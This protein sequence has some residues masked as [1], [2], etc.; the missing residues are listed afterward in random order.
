MSFTLENYFVAVTV[1]THGL[2][3]LWVF[4]LLVDAL[5]ERICAVKRYRRDFFRWYF[6]KDRYDGGDKT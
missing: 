2:A 4:F 6:G 3:F 5:I 1:L